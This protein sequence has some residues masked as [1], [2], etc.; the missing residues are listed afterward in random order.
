MNQ[1]PDQS[2]AAQAGASVSRATLEDPRVIRAVREYLAALEAGERPDRCTFEA[3][4]PEIAPALAG[5]LEAL[6]F[7][8][9][10]ASSL[11]PAL[12][13]EPAAALAATTELQPELPLGDYRIL[14]EI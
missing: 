4:Y 9:S 5:C 3:H 6:E 7:V 11:A 13:R 12:G 8:R 1:T 2:V 14:R 10:A